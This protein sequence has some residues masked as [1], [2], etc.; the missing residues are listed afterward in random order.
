[1]EM[2]NDQEFVIARLEEKMLD[3]TEENVYIIGQ[4]KGLVR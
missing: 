4:Y 2:Y 1:M 3:V